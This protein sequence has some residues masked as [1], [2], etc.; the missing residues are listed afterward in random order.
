MSEL[1]LEV[2][3]LDLDLAYHR[4]TFCA[5]GALVNPKT[6]HASE[7]PVHNDI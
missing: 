7:I 2:P 6:I 4:Y 3:L 5:K 1:K